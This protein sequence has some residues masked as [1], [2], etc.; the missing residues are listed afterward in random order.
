MMKKMWI[1]LILILVLSMAIGLAQNYL[2]KSPMPVFKKYILDTKTDRET[3]EDLSVYYQEMDAQTL[4]AL[5]QTDMMVLLDARTPDKYITGYIPGAINL[6]ITTFEKTY[7]AV[8]PKLEAGKTLVLYC[9]GY[10]CIDSALLAHQ[11]YLQGHREIYVYKGGFQEWQ[12]L[13]L[14]VQTP[15]GLINPEGKIQ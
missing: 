7:P 15:T 10:D 1:Q 12:N 3:G 6:P 11:L 14:P 5:Q 9:I 2:S 13:G 4:E 8:A